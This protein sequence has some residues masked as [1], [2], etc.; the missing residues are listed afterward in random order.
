MKSF[1]NFFKS[2]MV[3]GVMLLPSLAFANMKE[4]EAAEDLA[5]KI[6]S[7]MYTSI[8]KSSSA[9][10]SA[11]D[12]KVLILVLSLVAFGKMIYD[13]LESTDRVATG[14]LKLCIYASLAT[15][16]VDSGAYRATGLG[17]QFSAYTQSESTGY[18]DGDFIK[19][20]KTFADGLANA[21][22]AGD[23]RQQFLKARTEAIEYIVGSEPNTIDFDNPLSFWKLVTP[24][25][26]LMFAF[27]IVDLICAILVFITMIIFSAYAALTLIGFKLIV[28][29][30]VLESYRDEIKR[31]YKVPLA[32]AFFNA[33]NIFMLGI[34]AMIYSSLI[35]LL[36][37]YS[38]NVAADTTFRLVTVGFLV[39]MIA[40]Q[41]ACIWLIPRVARDILDLS[42]ENFT[43]LPG[44]IVKGGWGLG[45]L[46]AN[47]ASAIIGKIMGQAGSLGAGLF[48]KVKGK[49]AN[50]PSSEFSG[51]GPA[52]AAAFTNSQNGPSNM[53]GGAA[54]LTNVLG[55]LT[56]S[57]SPAAQ[58]P[59]GGSN[60]GFSNGPGPSAPSGT[61]QQPSGP[62]SGGGGSASPVVNVQPTDKKKIYNKSEDLE[63]I[64][65]SNDSQ[66]PSQPKASFS[67]IGSDENNGSYPVTIDVTPIKE[68]TLTNVSERDVG[69]DAGSDGVI[70]ADAVRDVSE[71]GLHKE[72]G[73]SKTK[74]VLKKAWG[75]TKVV[76]KITK[77]TA[78]YAG[79]VAAETA[80]LAAE[81]IPNWDKGANHVFDRAI[82]RADNI[83]GTTARAIGKDYLH[84][85]GQNKGKLESEVQQEKLKK[86]NSKGDDRSEK[87]SKNKTQES[88]ENNDKGNE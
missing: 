55:G 5:S 26:F 34:M 68:K 78:K 60:S 44:E 66:D 33:A 87:P 67:D 75:A 7:D 79:G 71:A 54:G 31:A 39:F 52:S 11:V 83:A 2:L 41:I 29:F 38:V 20:A 58:L 23:G 28:S 17:Q 8:L 70:D 59:Y 12:F 25:G 3:F 14:L 46:L 4:T 10:I 86:K 48:D 51:G 63:K 42:L 47:P 53:Y 37:S 84:I 36:K 22:F 77:E 73:V 56:S 64:V 19:A 18:L 50:N 6:A 85:H 65:S 21:L 27:T 80:K 88:D 74:S 9:L 81:T 24:S 13:G 16:C 72:K 30:M 69:G 43:K 1:A 61:P 82:D 62:S 35:T 45:M 15:F 32:S 76:A 49:F 40:A 57:S